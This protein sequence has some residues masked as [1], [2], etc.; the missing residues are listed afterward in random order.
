MLIARSADIGMQGQLRPGGLVVVQ[1]LL[2]ESLLEDRGDNAVAGGVIEAQGLDDFLN[3]N[4][5]CRHRVLLQSKG[6]EYAGQ[7]ERIP[8]S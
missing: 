6:R 5:R 7:R 2:V 4:P 8:M 3:W 1:W